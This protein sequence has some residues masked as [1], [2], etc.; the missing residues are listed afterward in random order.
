MLLRRILYPEFSRFAPGTSPA[1]RIAEHPLHLSG[2][3]YR[4]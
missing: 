4:I 2:G 1:N 3:N